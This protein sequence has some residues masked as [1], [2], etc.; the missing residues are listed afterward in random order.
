MILHQTE[1]METIY[2]SLSSSKPTTKAQALELL[3]L[4]IPKEDFLKPLLILCDSAEL[5]EKCQRLDEIQGMDIPD[6]V[7]I[8]QN[9]ESRR[10][11]K[12]AADIS[13]F[14]SPEP[15]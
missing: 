3:Q 9:E 1:V 14:P 2:R 4:T 6:A 12:M 15:A 8:L 13:L 7:I 11:R 5:S 10:C